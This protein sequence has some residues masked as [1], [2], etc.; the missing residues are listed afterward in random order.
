M[1]RKV[2]LCFVAVMLTVGVVLA[3]CA[4]EPT[5]G[6]RVELTVLIRTEDCRME[7]GDYASNVLEELGFKVVRQYG[8]SSELSPI[9]SGD[10][11]L[12]LWNMYTGA[13]ISTAVERDAGSNFGFFYTR[14]GAGIMGPLWA[15]YE[16]TEEFYTISEKLWFNDFS[17]TEE[18][19]D[20]FEDAMWMSMSEAQRNFLQ[21]RTSFS[22]LQ[23]DLHVAADSYGGISGSW[24]WG[25]TLHFRDGS[26]VPQVPTG[27]TTCRMA[28][29]DVL[30]NPWNPVAGSNWVYDMFPI[31]A[32][33][34]NGFLYDPVTG[35]QWPHRVVDAEVT[36]VDGLPIVSDPDHTG[37]LT[38]STVAD[39]IPVPDTAWADFD[40]TTGE[41]VTTAERFG[42]GQTAKA[43]TVVRYPESIWDV[44][45]HDGSTLDEGDFLLYA[46]MQFVRADVDSPL[47]DPSWVPTYE[48]L[49]SHFKGVEFNF[50]PGGGYGLEITTYGDQYYLDAEL[51]AGDEQRCWFP[52]DQFGQ[53]AWHNIALG[54]LAEEDLGLCFSQAKAAANTVEW[55]HFVD[56]PSL[57][58]LEGYLDD[59]L[60]SGSGVYG[61]IPFENV[62]G[63]YIDQSDALAR[64]GNL[65]TWYTDK[66]HFW[67]GSGPYYVEDVDSVGQ[68]MELGRHTTYPDDAARW[69]F[70]MDPVPTTP[71][72]HTGGWF[73]VITIEIAAEAAA[74]SMLGSD[75]LDVYAYA[76]ADAALMET[77][78][79][80]PNIW[81][82]MNAGLFDELT[83]NPSGEFFP[84][85]GELNPFAIPEVREAMHWAMD[86]DYITGTIMGGMGLPRINAVGSLSGDGV[87]YADILD[88]INEY[89]A[90]DFD[91]A[92]AAIEEAMLAITGVTRDEL[93]H[94]YYAAP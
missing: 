47:Y 32:T 74:V 46:I 36:W 34:D 57:A 86:S 35:L 8:T 58:V 83:F 38:T 91:Q 67:V 87:K 88:A 89:Y 93:G 9:W 81:Y 33:G 39:P 43:K 15:A 94:Y 64:Y 27:S 75:L 5:Y 45:L 40:A 82:Y 31:R 19:N 26:G 76:I 66:G 11:D 61:Y 16:N 70:T 53:W 84:G 62:L 22:P 4:E 79:D 6:E 13:W 30:T 54:I 1:A 25:L 14:L 24:L 44:P 77:C 10:P 73:D 12:G 49:M 65:D 42:S 63:D 52:A 92:D 60:D 59:V 71:P 78:D 28:M 90:Y 50:S 18:R 41:F 51:I 55:M 3:G 20:L 56:G 85:T 2:L 80:D 29:T 69:F 68:V 17:T 7:I 21:D 37:W 23:T 48:A 72:A